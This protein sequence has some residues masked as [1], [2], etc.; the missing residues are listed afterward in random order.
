MLQ[1]QREHKE[2]VPKV[3]G[4]STEFLKSSADLVKRSTFGLISSVRA[5]KFWPI[6][7]SKNNEDTQ[8]SFNVNP[9]AQGFPCFYESLHDKCRISPF[10]TRYSK[11]SMPENFNKRLQL[12]QS[13]IR[14]ATLSET[15]CYG[16][17]VSDIDHCEYI[18]Y[19]TEK[20]R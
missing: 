3:L 13:L 6:A 19:L 9:D 2:F 17:E 5:T 1:L 11:Y 16:S 12:C 4:T 18:T 20:Y 14:I 7:N 8:E 10:D 15:T